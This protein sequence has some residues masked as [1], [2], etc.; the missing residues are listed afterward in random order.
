M[1]RRFFYYCILMA[2]IFVVLPFRVGADFGRDGEL[3]ALLLDIQK[4]SNQF[5]FLACK[6]TQERHLSLF[7]QPVLFNETLA[8]IRPGHL[9]WEYI[10][11]VPSVLI[12]SGNTGLR[13]TGNNNREYDYAISATGIT[14]LLSGT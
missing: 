2:I 3:N 4:K 7:S 1:M 14:S 8:I 10:D 11:P 9:R 6:F 13:C 12:F 5:Q